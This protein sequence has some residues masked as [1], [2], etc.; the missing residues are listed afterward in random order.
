MGKQEIVLNLGA[1]NRPIAGAINVD[2]TRHRE[3]INCVHDLNVLPWPWEDEAFDLIVA[4]AVFEHLRH[5]LIVSMDE[6]WRLL[7]PTGRIYV[8]LPYWNSEISHLDPTH[9]WKYALRTMEW[10]DPR[11][12]YGKAYGFYTARKWRIVKGPRL[13]RS[14]SSIH[15]TLEVWK[16]WQPAS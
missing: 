5:D 15:T 16:S 10:F 14:R 8:K 6:A 4:R 1:G 11:T 9:Y 3:E 12:E 7:R 13:N 2:R